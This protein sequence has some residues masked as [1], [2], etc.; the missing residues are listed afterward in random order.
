MHPAAQTLHLTGTA[1]GLVDA[2]GLVRLLSLPA[3]VHVHVH[4]DGQCVTFDLTHCSHPIRELRHVSNALGLLL[5]DFPTDNPDGTAAHEF[6]AMG[7]DSGILRTFRAVVQIP[8][9][10]PPS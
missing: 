4:D 5:E 7:Y 3:Q 9:T 10:W 6:R 8:A 1:R 2:L